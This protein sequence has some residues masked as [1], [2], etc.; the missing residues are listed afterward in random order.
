MLKNIQTIL[1]EIKEELDAESARMEIEFPYFIEKTAPVSGARSLMEY[2]CWF[3]SKNNGSK[4]DFPGGVIVVPVTTVC[5]CSKEIS[6]VSAHNR[7]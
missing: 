1:Q 7:A 6:T 2:T 4:T 5:P 3:C